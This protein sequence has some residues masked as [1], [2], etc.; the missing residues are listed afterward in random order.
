MSI[1]MNAKVGAGDGI[2]DPATDI[3]LRDQVA[4]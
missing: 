4:R 2:G 3:A 1:E